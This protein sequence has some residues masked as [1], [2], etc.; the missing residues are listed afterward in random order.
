M[1]QTMGIW[2]V[3]KDLQEFW[4]EIIKREVCLNQYAKSLNSYVDRS[5]MFSSYL[6]SSYFQRMFTWLPLILLTF[7]YWAIKTWSCFSHFLCLRTLAL[8][9]EA[10]FEVEFV[11]RALGKKKTKEWPLC[12]SWQ[13]G[14]WM[15]LRIF[16]DAPSLVLCNNFASFIHDGISISDFP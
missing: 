9:W 11:S 14:S 10:M 1:L 8:E 13:W 2:H 15:D 12:F 6:D 7:E 4:I 5:Y 16:I 3:A